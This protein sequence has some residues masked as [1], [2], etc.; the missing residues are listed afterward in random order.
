MAKAG[1]AQKAR[2]EKLGYALVERYSKWG[3]RLRYND[4]TVAMACDKPFDVW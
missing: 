1:L 2:D 4:H 3:G